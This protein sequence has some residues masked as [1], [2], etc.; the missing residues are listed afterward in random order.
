MPLTVSS[1]CQTSVAFVCR[2]AQGGLRAQ[3]GRWPPAGPASP[4]ACS[5]SPGPDSRRRPLGDP[6]RCQT[7]DVVGADRAPAIAREQVLH[8]QDI[9]GALLHQTRAPT[10][11]VTYRALRLRID[12]PLRQQS[13]PQQ[14]RQPGRVGVIIAVLQPTVLHDRRRIGQVHLV[15]CGHQG[16]DQPVPIVGRLHDQ[17]SDRLSIRLQHFQDSLRVIGQALA[18]DDP[19]VVAHSIDCALAEGEQ[20]RRA[21]YLSRFADEI[22]KGDLTAIRDA[23][24]GAFALGSERFQRQIA[25]M[26][27]RRTWPALRYPHKPALAAGCISH[28]P[29]FSCSR[30]VARKRA[31]TSRRVRPT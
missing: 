21:R 11:Q 18:I 30:R 2:Q 12:K 23:T 6:L 27:G 10:Q 28:G 5:G 9:G 14:L 7:P 26:V 1:G 24:N 31:P 15:A 4:A 25:S 22:P 20:A 17:A 8:R 13:E 16:I 3:A 29:S 19:V